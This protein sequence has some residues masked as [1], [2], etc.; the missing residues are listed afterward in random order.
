M[1]LPVK[2]A[3]G[4]VFRGIDLE[5]QLCILAVN[6]AAKAGPCSHALVSPD[7]SQRQWAFQKMLLTHAQSVAGM[8]LHVS[9]VSADSGLVMWQ[10]ACTNM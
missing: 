10:A 9:G 5:A 2:D 4:Q 6:L 3:L 1:A 7:L 8:R